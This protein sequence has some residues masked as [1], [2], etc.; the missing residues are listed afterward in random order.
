MD[1][2]NVYLRAFTSISADWKSVG[3]VRINCY[4]SDYFISLILANFIGY[5]MLYVSRAYDI[6]YLNLQK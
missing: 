5:Q 1:E 6:V 2:V 3:S 4:W